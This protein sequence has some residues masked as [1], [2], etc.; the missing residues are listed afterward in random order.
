MSRPAAKPAGAASQPDPL[1]TSVGYI[2][3]DS[4]LRQR[5]QEA[6]KQRSGPGGQ[7][8]TGRSR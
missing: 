2:G 7:R 5:K 1:K 4:L 6:L 8:R 3:A